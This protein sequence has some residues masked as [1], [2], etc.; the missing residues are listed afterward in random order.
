V[1]FLLM[2]M[3]HVFM[4]L[5]LG[6]FGDGFQKR[7]CTPRQQESRACMQSQSL[8]RTGKPVPTIGRS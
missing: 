8:P 2:R 3:L 1:L 5:M 7:D 4:R 6:T